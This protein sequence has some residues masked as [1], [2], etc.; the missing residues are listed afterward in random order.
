VTVQTKR[1]VLVAFVLAA[2][3]LPAEGILLKA[4]QV[5]SEEQAAEAFVAGL[6]RAQLHVEAG[7]ITLHKLAYRRAIMR[8]LTPDQRSQVWREHIYAYIRAY[9]DLPADAVA[10]LEA[11]AASASTA[12]FTLPTAETRAATAAAAAQVEAHLGRT[13]AEYLLYRLGPKD[14]QYAT[15]E[16]VSDKLAAWVRE[17]FVLTARIEDCDCNKDFGCESQMFCS[18][19]TAC[20]VDT[21]W[22]AC[23]WFWN[24]DC[25]GLCKV[26]LPSGG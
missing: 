16:P 8:A 20:T 7:R 17:T 10:A 3:L 22:P 4:L 11:A 23:G 12:A 1:R 24:E 6:S 9:P 13:V 14:G 19:T 2:L 15:I 18:D 5:T 21:E 26:G 25:N